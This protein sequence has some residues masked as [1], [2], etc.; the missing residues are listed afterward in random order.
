MFESNLCLISRAQ[1]ET[2]T[3][4]ETETANT[5]LRKE[6]FFMTILPYKS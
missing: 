5:F 4:T 6:Y 2:E 1:T 3:E